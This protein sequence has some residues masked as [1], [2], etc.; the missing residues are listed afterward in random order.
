MIIFQEKKRGNGNFSGKKPGGNGNFS[1]KTGGIVIFQSLECFE[2]CIFYLE[3][4]KM[5]YMTNYSA[6][7]CPEA[8][9]KIAGVL[10]LSD[11]GVSGVRSMG[12][13]VSH[14]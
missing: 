9:P 5:L 4:F 7:V 12:P 6:E 11:P 14:Y 10:F 3:H 1:E 13:V 8:S 2:N